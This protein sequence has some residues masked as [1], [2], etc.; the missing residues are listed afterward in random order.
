[1]AERG[2]NRLAAMGGSATSAGPQQQQQQLHL[3]ADCLRLWQIAC[4][5][6]GTLIHLFQGQMRVFL[7][8]TDDKLYKAFVVGVR[9]LNHCG[10][11]VMFAILLALLMWTQVKRCGYHQ[12]GIMPSFIRKI[13][14][15]CQVVQ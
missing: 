14:S 15:L 8:P 5:G 6:R 11:Q 4:H 12:Y 10:S 13:V 7:M 2:E 1:M 3:V 9:I